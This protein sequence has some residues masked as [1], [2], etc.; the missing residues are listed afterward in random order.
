MK[1]IAQNVARTIFC[2]SKLIPTLLFLC[3]KYLAQKFGLLCV[4]LN[5]L[6]KENSRPIGEKSPNLVT[7]TQRS[8]V[9]GTKSAFDTCLKGVGYG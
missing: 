4:I 9:L 3:K 1:K 8:F 6:S 2:V 7:L 5:I